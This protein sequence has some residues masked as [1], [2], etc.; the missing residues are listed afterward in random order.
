MVDNA[1]PASAGRAARTRARRQPEPLVPGSDAHKCAFCH[2]LLDTHDPYRPAVIAWPRLDPATRARVVGLP[3]WD[4]AVQTE[5]K[6]RLRVLAY[7]GTVA[8]PLLRRAIELDAF[9]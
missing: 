9:E 5:G 3:I 2:M 8:D 4:I 6:A 1:M 7:A